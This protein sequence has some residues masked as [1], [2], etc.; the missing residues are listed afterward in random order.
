MSAACAPRALAHWRAS[1]R[2]PHIHL[3]FG[4][5]LALSLP[6]ALGQSVRALAVWTLPPRGSHG[7]RRLCCLPSCSRAMDDTFLWQPANFWLLLGGSVGI[8]L[9]LTFA[10]RG[11]FLFRERLRLS[12]LLVGLCQR[13]RC[14]SCSGWAT[15]SSRC[16][17]RSRRAFVSLSPAT[18][19]HV[20]VIGPL[21][22]LVIGPGEELLA[23]TGAVGVC[24]SVWSGAAA[25]GHAGLRRHDVVSLNRWWSI[26]AAVAGVV[27]AGLHALGRLAPGLISHVL[28]DLAYFLVFPIH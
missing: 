19:G 28:W 20:R 6:V 2:P 27:G 26:A 15:S 8:L 5:L 24:R 3:L 14:G 4:L 16:C 17:C 18:S 23:G 7:Y 10:V 21:L 22:A 9:A 1:I 11:P 25:A 12:D 13:R